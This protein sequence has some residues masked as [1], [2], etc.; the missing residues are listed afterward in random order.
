MVTTTRSNN[1]END[2]VKISDLTVGQYKLLQQQL[3]E[4]VV[5]QVVK[6]EIADVKEDVQKLKKSVTECM[7]VAGGAH[8]RAEY[9]VDF[10][11]SIEEG[12][13]T[14]TEKHCA[15][16]DKVKALAMENFNTSDVQ[17]EERMSTEDAA[18]EAAEQMENEK[19]WVFTTAAGPQQQQLQQELPGM[20]FERPASVVTRPGRNGTQVTK[21]SFNSV[22]QASAAVNARLRWTLQRKGIYTERALTRNQQM[23]KK[24]VDLPLVKTVRGPDFGAAY[25][26]GR[27]IVWKKDSM[28]RRHGAVVTIHTNQFS[29]ANLPKT[30]SDHRLQALLCKAFAPPATPSRPSTPQSPTT[31]ATGTAD[32]DMADADA[33]GTA[34]ARAASTA[35][36]AGAAGTAGARAA[37]AGTAST[38]AASRAGTAGA[39]R[40][41]ASRAGTA[42][43]GTGAASTGSSSRQQHNGDPR[44]RQSEGAPTPTQPATTKARTAAGEDDQ[45]A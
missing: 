42:T 34:G 4:A 9:A 35:G 31:S 41:S 10:G 20:L 32:A 30:I 44:K 17:Q 7:K 33:A 25:E 37:G 22:P 8:N 36:A 21:V 15:L 39:G 14:L 24:T 27:V 19:T 40:A 3:V 29:E 23:R 45:A 5:K 28:G 6:Q 26:D 38:G 1:K 11:K 43:A 12:L 16:E 2:D 13:V 18:R